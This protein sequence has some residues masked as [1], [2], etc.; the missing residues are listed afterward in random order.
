MVRSSTLVCSC[1][2]DRRIWAEVPF[3]GP[4]YLEG[5]RCLVAACPACAGQCRGSYK[6]G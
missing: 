2:G 6:A 3:N 1:C 4:R 5:K